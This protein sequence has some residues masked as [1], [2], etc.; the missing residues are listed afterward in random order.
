[1]KM[2]ALLSVSDKS[3]IVTLALGLKD[4][5]YEI[6]ST[7]GTASL[8]RVTPLEVTGVQA[9]TGF[10]ELMDGRVKTLHP[11]VFAGILARRAYSPDLRALELLGMKTIDVVVVNLYPF[12][13]TAENPKSTFDDLVENIDIGGPSMIRAAARNFRDVLV[14]VDPADYP[15]VLDELRQ[16]GGPSLEF[17]FMLMRKAIRHTGVYDMTIAEEMDQM[18]DIE[19][20]QVV[21]VRAV[22]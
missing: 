10:P 15:R 12:A 21:R 16:E 1:M 20:D 14:V 6:V 13:K 3:G 8:L 19:G 11:A 17:R 2:R 22:I 4:L 18:T 9:L 7:G 5:G